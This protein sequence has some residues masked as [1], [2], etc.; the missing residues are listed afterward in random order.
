MMFNIIIFQLLFCILLAPIQAKAAVEQLFIPNNED[1]IECFLLKPARETSSPVIFLL[2]GY[3]PPENGIG[4][5]QLVDYGYLQPFAKEGI[6]A[7]SI[8]M[9]G[10][11]NSTGFRDFGGPDSQKAII[12]VIDYVKN[13]PFVDSSRM[14]IY[15]ISRGAQLAGMV[16]SRYPNMKLQILESGFYD[17]IS[18]QTDTPNYLEGIRKSIV[19]EGG[20]NLEALI[21]RSLIYHIDEINASTLILQ[22]EFDD[23]RQ[24]PAA[25]IIH[26]ELIK[27]NINSRLVMFRNELHELPKDKWDVILPFVRQHFFNLY[28]IGIKVSDAIP[29]IQI[30]KIHPGSSAENIQKLKI[31]D[32][33]L[34]ISPMNDDTEISLLRMPVDQFISLV[35]GKKDTEL[36]LQ[37]QHF[38]LSIEDIVIKRG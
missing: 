1:T 10:Y 25:Q 18:F 38:D 14:G 5:K 9:P 12:A 34:S 30:A 35:L 36:R 20:T 2:H 19:V 23:R 26:E 28:G 32:A 22:G 29:A 17:L 24:L 33:L 13:L 3:Q 11:G 27:R 8:S 37:V 6:V 31:G 15:G 7:V 21:E 16:T 4:G